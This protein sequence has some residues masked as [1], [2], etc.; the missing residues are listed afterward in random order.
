M[1]F[2]ALGT[3]GPQRLNGQ[4]VNATR[5]MARHRYHS[6]PP[7]VRGRPLTPGGLQMLANQPK[8]AEE[9]PSG[10]QT[11]CQPQSQELNEYMAILSHLVSWWLVT[12]P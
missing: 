4:P 11:N 3:L 7:V 5:H 6:Q 1:G 8:P 9:L 10:A 2:V 12:Q